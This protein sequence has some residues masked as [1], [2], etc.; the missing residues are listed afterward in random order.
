MPTD[1]LQAAQ[2]S[3]ITDAEVEAGRR[4]ADWLRERGDANWGALVDRLTS[5]ASGLVPATERLE[6]T[7]ENNHG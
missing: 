4:L 1:S 5:A 2:M 3:P 7:Q 6:S